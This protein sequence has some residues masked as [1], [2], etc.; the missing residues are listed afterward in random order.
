MP[1]SSDSLLLFLAVAENGT[2]TAAAQRL[3]MTQPALTQRIRRLENQL[4]V[5]LLERHPKGVT[6]TSFGKALLTYA[7][8]VR[9]SIKQADAEILAMRGGRTGSVRVGAG[10]AWAGTILP[11]AIERIHRRRPGLRIEV[12][13]GVDTQLKAGLRRGEYDFIVLGLPQDL[14]EDPDLYSEI[15]F[16][17]HFKVTARKDHPLVCAR[18]DVRLAELLDYPWGSPQRNQPRTPKS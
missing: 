8:E 12:I 7:S 4:G 5:H 2:F 9:T 3:G 1:I 16:V 11:R 18:R 10:P 15:W 13:T 17:D 14:T 6:T